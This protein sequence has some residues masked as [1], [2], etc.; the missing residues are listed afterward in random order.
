MRRLLGV[1]VAVALLAGAGCTPAAPGA[2]VVPEPT[3]ADSA[4]AAP[5]SDSPATVSPT[6][7]TSPSSDPAATEEPTD[8]S[9]E[10][11]GDEASEPEVSF[12]KAYTYRDGLKVEVTRIKHGRITA[13][14]VKRRA[15]QK[16]G[17]PWVQLT[18]RVQNGS[19]KPLSD[20]IGSFTLIYGSDGD[21]ADPIAVPGLDDTD[22]TGSISR[23]ATKTCSSTFSVPLQDQDHVFL[24][25]TPDINHGSI[26]FSGSIA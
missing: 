17:T 2:P 20:P 21:E 4:S 1:T 3:S 8:E 10:E 23:G 5:S 15:R 12:E 16:K 11:Q 6:A 24:E 25:F 7:S 19:K 18:V 9:V 22:L 26:L 14:D 13:D